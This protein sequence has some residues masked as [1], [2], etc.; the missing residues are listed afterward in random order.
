LPLYLRAE[1][2][3]RERNK[4][5]T[6]KRVENSKKEIAESRSWKKIN[7]N[8]SNDHSK[9][10][11]ENIKIW[12]KQ[13]EKH[14]KE[15]KELMEEKERKELTFSPILNERSVYIMKKLKEI[16]ETKSPQKS[17][18]K[19][20]SPHSRKNQS[21]SPEPS[22]RPEISNKAKKLT[23]HRTTS[24]FER[25]YTPPKIQKTPLLVKTK[26]KTKP[27]KPQVFFERSYSI[28]SGNGV[29]FNKNFLETL[30]E[31]K[32]AKYSLQ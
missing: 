10:F 30:L 13:K 28:N 22:F 21:V 11:F 26:P 3:V 19:S 29:V 5:I 9:K 6:L 32:N 12:Q 17:P 27:K 25:L 18:Q 7:S 15:Q 24:V 16:Q 2:I 1:Q 31:E 23:L 4:S 8:I 14:V 20:V